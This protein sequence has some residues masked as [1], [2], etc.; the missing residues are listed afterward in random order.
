[1]IEIKEVKKTVNELEN[2]INNYSVIRKGGPE[3]DKRA[4]SPCSIHV[5]L[6]GHLHVLN[7]AHLMLC[8]TSIKG[9]VSDSKKLFP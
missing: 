2:Q 1:L 3:L 8:M 5:G 4:I 6:L 9:Y 7:T